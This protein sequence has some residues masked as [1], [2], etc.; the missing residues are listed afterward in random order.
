MLNWAMIWR[1]SPRQYLQSP[2]CED[3]VWDAAIS[4]RLQYKVSSSEVKVLM[5]RRRWQDIFS[6]CWSRRTVIQDPRSTFLQPDPVPKY[7]QALSSPRSE[8]PRITS[9]EI[10]HFRSY[11]RHSSWDYPCCR[12]QTRSHKTLYDGRL[13]AN[14][15]N[16]IDRW[17][18]NRIGHCSN[19][20]A[21]QSCQFRSI[22]QRRWRLITFAIV[23]WRI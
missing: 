8:Y 11:H 4:D 14:F 10:H 21:L 16:I 18:E 6:N 15:Y 19:K 9:W 20:F 23:A 2:T 5:V 17:H 12:W 3:W 1:S 13:A 22:A 7:W